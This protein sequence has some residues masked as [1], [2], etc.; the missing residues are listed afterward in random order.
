[1]LKKREKDIIS[2]FVAEILGLILEDCIIAMI[3]VL[4]QARAFDA[5]MIIIATF[6]VICA[7]LR[8]LQLLPAVSS[9]LLPYLLF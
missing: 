5:A 2:C 3:R 9:T 1:M 4:N 8:I 7:H 6:S